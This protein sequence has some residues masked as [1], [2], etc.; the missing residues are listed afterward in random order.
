MAQYTIKA[1]HGQP[2]PWESTKGGPMLSYR[3]DLADSSG[4]VAQKVE[5]A[6]K[7][8]TPA[9]SVGDTIDGEITT[10]TYGDPPREDLRFK[11]EYGGGGGGRGG[12]R[13]YLE[14]D[15]AIY[16]AKQAAIAAQTSIER[17]TELVLA[18]EP[19]AGS[20]AQ[21]ADEVL[22]VASKYEAHVA[23]SA[24]RAAM[25]VRGDK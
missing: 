14:D 18:R 4:T 13:K 2:K 8:D 15:P 6:Q 16:A 9:P 5:L 21:R 22:A 24:R 25:R 17:A 1:I 20:T 23:E 12:G 3:V 10:R 7:K 11:K 19:N